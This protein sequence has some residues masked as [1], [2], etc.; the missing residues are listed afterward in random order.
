MYKI[1]IVDDD[2][3]YRN[4]LAEEFNRP[5]EQVI[6]S[7][8]GV[9]AVAIAENEQPDMILLDV[10]LP[11][12]LGINVIEDLKLN[13]QTK[14]IPVIAMS[15]FGGEQNKDRALSVG[16]ADFITKSVLTT[17][18]IAEQVRKYFIS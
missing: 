17:A 11:K 10:M 5:D 7:Q 2:Q 9:E 12:K 3:F 15:N 6:F 13:Q 16:A 18:E 1:L 8:D 14:Y 4:S